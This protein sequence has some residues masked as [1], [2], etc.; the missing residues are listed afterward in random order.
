M[1]KRA[2]PAFVGTFVIGALALAIAAVALLGSGTLFRT[3]HKFVCFFDGNVNGLRVGAAVKFKGVEIGEVRQILLSLNAGTGP[4]TLGNSSVIK[5]P[6]IIEL[7]EGRILKRG[8][9]YINVG[10]PAGMKL[11]ISRGL[12]A[13]L[14]LES[15]LTGL[16]YVDLDM[17]PN[18]PERFST[19]QNPNQTYTE[20]PT[21]PTAFEQ[22]QSV[23]TKLMNQLDKVQLD[24]L[25]TT[26]TQALAAL[27]DL[28][29]SQDLKDS[30]VSLKETGQNLDKTSDSIRTLTAHLDRQIGPMTASIRVTAQNADATF[31]QTQATLARLDETLQPDAPLLYQ[32]NHTLVDLGEAAR[33][34]RHLAEYLERNP[35]AILRGRAYKKGA[36]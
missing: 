18:S 17:H 31:K 25:V 9:T 21:L 34:I 27:R 20:I 3:T 1:A 6:V 12:R 16:L 7:D 35:D 5:I 33:A 4:V 10:N 28:A 2:N 32:A 23:A 24:Q 11:A 15:L 14:S 8:A 36:Q 13:Q 29:A 26:A 30:I 19:T 22:A